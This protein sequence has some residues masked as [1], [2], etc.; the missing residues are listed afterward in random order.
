M[1]TIAL[2]FLGLGIVLNLA[3]VY[4]LL[5]P[6]S[7]SAFSVEGSEILSM[8]WGKITMFDVYAGFMLGLAI[9]WLLEPKLWVKLVLTLTLPLLGNPIL[10]IWI[11]VRFKL[12]M[13][14]RNPD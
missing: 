13:R 1:R 9:V 5:Q 4:L 11:A 7:W 10:A 2:A 6:T 3:L 12:L 8:V 14:L